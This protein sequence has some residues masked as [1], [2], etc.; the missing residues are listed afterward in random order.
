MSYAR[1]QMPQIGQLPNGVWYAMGFGGHGIST[2]T[3]AGEVIAEA[4]C[5]GTPL[6]AGLEQF[7][8]PSVFGLPGLLAAQFTYWYFELRDW[9]KQ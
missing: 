1:H 6:P 3:L 8:L 5:T 9:W 2:T 4:I 7:G